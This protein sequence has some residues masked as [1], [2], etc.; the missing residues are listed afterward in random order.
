MQLVDS[1]SGLELIADSLADARSLFLDTEFDSSREGRVLCVLQISD[2]GRIHLI[3]TLRLQNLDALRPVLAAPDREWVL[4]AGSQDVELLAERFSLKQPPHVFDTQVAW[5][6]TS[7]EHSVSLAYL[8][9]QLLSVRTGKSHQADDWK[10][11]PLPAAQLAYA[12][13]DIED[14]PSLHESLRARLAGVGREGIV[15]AAS[16]EATWPVREAPDPLSLSSFRNAWQLDVHS[17]AALRFLI[18]WFN[19]LA[20]PERA[21][22]PDAKTLL[23]IASRLPE[24]ADAL[25][26][27]KGVPRRFAAARG[28]R[29]T[30]EMMRATATADGSDFVPID[31]PP[32]AT[33][34]EIRLDGWLSL[35]R[36]EIACE[37][38]V[39]PELAFP[40]RLLRKLRQRILESGDRAAGADALE[41]W[42]AELCGE[43]W[44]QFARR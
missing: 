4:H 23:A 31:P 13:S 26:R 37:L 36:A 33:F 8:R 10:R 35:A 44:R 28:A 41:G 7:A 12:A 6:L 25:S 1:Q 32:Y 17:Q 27:I 18:E 24:D 39:A 5:A 30:G 14:L 29:L 43:A 21:Q 20:P 22:A 3:D 38:G 2:G 34:E 40:N 15:H 16:I 9:F 11:R 42:R 19:E